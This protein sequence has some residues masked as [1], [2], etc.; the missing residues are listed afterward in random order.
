[1]MSRAFAISEE[2]TQ[3]IWQKLSSPGTVLKPY[4][5]FSS[6]RLVNKQLKFVLST[7]FQGVFTEILRKISALLLKSRKELWPQA[8]AA[9]LALSIVVESLQMMILCKERLNQLDLS[10]SSS[11][12]A[13]ADIRSID[14]QF[15]FLV[16][17]LQTKYKSWGISCWRPLSDGVSR[18]DLVEA[19]D[20]EFVDALA[21]VVE[22]HGKYWIAIPIR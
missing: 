2:T 4:G 20:R 3:S 22:E 7:V 9:V 12:K 10:P 21:M 18:S 15:H 5:T 19:A 13:G 6:P 17:L 16:Q 11:S 8:F 1:M 14:D